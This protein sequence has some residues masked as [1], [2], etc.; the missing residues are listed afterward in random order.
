MGK[1][2]GETNGKIR[3]LAAAYLS[4]QLDLLSTENIWYCYL[5]L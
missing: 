3:L 4:T 2:M 5:Y 1:E